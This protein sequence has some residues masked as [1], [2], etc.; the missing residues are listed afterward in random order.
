[1]PLPE[2]P[3]APVAPTSSVS[4]LRDASVAF[5]YVRPYRARFF[6][7]LVASTISMS[8]G[9]SFPFLV[10]RLLDAAVLPVRTPLLG[11]W[12]PSIG[13]VA[14]LLAGT[15]L[16]QAVLMFFTSY[17]FYQ[18]GESSVVALRRDLYSRL[19]SLPLPFF[20]RHQV[21]ELANRISSDLALIQET[22]A[23]GIPQFIRQALMLVGG[24]VFIAVTSLKLLLV[25]I[26]TLP[27]L[28]LCAVAFGR[29]IRR[30]SRQAQDRLAAS[31]AMV[32]DALHGIATV[33]AFGAE[34]WEERRYGASLAGYLATALHAGRLRAGLIAFIIL[35]IFG[36]ILLLLWVGANMIQTGQLTH[37]EFTRFILYTAFVGGAVPSLAEVFGQ[38]QRTLGATERVR[39]LLEE[40]PE[41]G[42]GDTIPLSLRGVVTFENV[43]FRYPSRPETEVLRG[44]SLQANPGEKIALVGPSGGGKSTLLSLLLRFYDPEAGAVLLDGRDARTLSPAAIRATMA[45]VSQDVFLF[46]GTIRENIAYGRPGASESEILEAS[47]RA[48]C[49][50]FIQPFPNGYETRVGDRGFQL[51]GGQRQRIAIARA[52]LK[53][54]AILILDEAAS[55]LDSE[56]EQAVQAAIAPLLEGRTAIIVAHRL[57]TVRAVDRIYVIDGGEVKEQGTHAELMALGGL[58]RRLADL[59]FSD[60]ATVDAVQ[61]TCLGGEAS[62]S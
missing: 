29:T 35:G 18:V 21:G 26:F 60:S 51:S 42:Q 13:T 6:A 17:W 40:K 38:I 22:L 34:A 61:T 39:E 32:N 4:A 25:M 50:G 31:A 12:T 23:H 41:A 8:V 14:L 49:H 54:P 30:L 9:L 53:N 47:R 11:A 27:L 55:A 48:N 62:D 3:G 44:I 37:G 46:G 58:Y 28:A 10:G 59:Q 24:V 7:A 2:T 45:L 1:M 56:S 43:R 57:S 16:I 52:L 19:I 15:L 36:S 33:K 5:G 20:G